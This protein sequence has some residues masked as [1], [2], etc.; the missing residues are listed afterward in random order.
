VIEF[1]NVTFKYPE[2]DAIV[3]EDFSYKIEKDS[4]VAFVGPS[5]SGKST[6]TQI[7]QRFYP[8]QSGSI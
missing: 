6:I 4:K 1:K 8:L 5:G 3:L 7:L 2:R